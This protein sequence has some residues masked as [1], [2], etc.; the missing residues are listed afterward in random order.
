MNDAEST[1]RLDIANRL[2]ALN[3]ALERLE[4]FLEA[5]GAPLKLAYVARLTLEELATN[6]IKYGYDNPDEHH[7]GVVVQLGSPATMTI[8]DDGH[9]FNPLT[10]A[11]EPDLA[12]SAEDR[13]IGGLGLHM[14]KSLTASL[15]YQRQGHHNRLRVVFADGDGAT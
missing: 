4:A 5:E 6:T 10:D 8:E 2:D 11:P 13:P 12:A 3:E 7:I 14:V 1:L 9:P 15:D